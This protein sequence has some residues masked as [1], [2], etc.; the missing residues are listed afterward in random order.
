MEA[1]G[2]LAGGVAHDFNNLLTVI[3]GY[4]TLTLNELRHDDPLRTNVEEIRAASDRAAALT[5]QLLAFSRRQILQPR[6]LDLNAVIRNMERMLRR[7]IGE[8]IAFRS[9]L[10]PELGHIRA[11]PGQIEQVVM[12]LVV[13]A[14]DAM[15][16]GGALTIATKHVD[17]G[18]GEAGELMLRGAG[19]HVALILRDTGTGMDEA[20]RARIFEP[21]FTTK[22]AGKGTGLGLSTVYGIVKQSGGGI[23]VDTEVGRGTTFTLY[24]L[25][26]AAE[27][28]DHAARVPLRASPKGSE[29]VLVA[30]DDAMV[31]SLIRRVLRAHGYETLEAADGATAVRLCE[32]HPGPIH[33]LLTDVVMPELGGRELVE[34]LAQL[35]PE[36]R[37]LFMSG[38]TDDAIVQH[39]VP[40]SDIP[41]VQKPFTPDALARKVREVLDAAWEPIA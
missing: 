1:V 10:A 35:R 21:F 38:Y 24:F 32:R 33:L 9:M 2:R 40:D 30:E 37:V 14:R 13:N 34:R 3:A 15:P 5:R 20:T 26:L 25:R 7:I 6:E 18:A 39:G 4:S 19:P 27:I 28:D 41:F 17:L 22:E 29:T 31:R 8:D 11:D 12:N 23:R 36:M 16:Q